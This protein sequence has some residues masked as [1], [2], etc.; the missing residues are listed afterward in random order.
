MIKFVHL[1]YFF[2]L[3]SL[4]TRAQYIPKFDVQGH[5]GAR[6]LKPENT[7][8][9]F[10]EALNQG[11]TTVELDLAITKD[12]QVVVSHE[13]WMSAAICLQPEGTPITPEE[14]KKFNIYQL[15]YE[16]VSR[17]DC[18]SKGNARFNEQEKMKA[19]KPLLSAVIAA[20]E[21]HIKSYTLYEVDYNIEL[22]S[23]PAGDNLFHPV[24]EEF[25]DLVYQV[26]NEY[27]PLNRVVIQSFDFRVLRHWNIKYPSVRLAALVDNK[28]PV[29][30][31]LEKLG[32]QPSVYSCDYNLLTPEDVKMLKQKKIRVIPWTVNEKADME[33]LKKMDVD[34]LITDYPN[35]AAELGLGLKPAWT[36][37]K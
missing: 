12:R 20:V 16:Q 4:S 3:V 25:C 32:F 34:G 35:R 23:L 21:D 28:E 2:Y 11:V 27:L 22:K 6:G 5:R 19:T 26:L 1:F 33:R 15:T 37:V 29:E 10:I 18:G 14:E 17:F 24:P 36:K 30:K 9:S 7:I 31:N 8:P 13:P